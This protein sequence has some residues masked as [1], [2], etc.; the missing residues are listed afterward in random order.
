M[1]DPLPS[2]RSPQNV[3][4]APASAPPTVADDRP[5]IWTTFVV[6][7]TGLALAVVLQVVVAVL[8]AFGFAMLGVDR[9]DL[10]QRLLEWST[11]QS[12]FLV[13]LAVGQIGFAIPTLAAAAISPVPFKER[14]G[15][16]GL[17]HAVRFSALM[18]A[19]S[20]VPLA[21]ALGLATAVAQVVPENEALR[22]FYD[23]LTPARAIVFVLLVAL[24]PGFVEEL[25]F[26]GYIQRRLLARWRPGWAIGVT[27]LVFTLSHIEPVAM[28]A[29]LPLG[30]W[31]GIIAW[32]VGSIVPTIV[33]HAFVNGGLNL[34]RLTV[35]F[36]EL[37]ETTERVGNISFLAVGCVC[38]VVA[39]RALVKVERPQA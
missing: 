22:T 28:A 12:G 33:C 20:I 27:S 6:W 31:F 3:F 19:G 8:A 24:A 21:V 7:L 2:D 17:P 35:Q 32:R 16:V 4:A 29:A 15:L 5:R 10:R 23:Q 11:V 34:W 36:A 18:A 38:F 9:A 30:I 39:C 26:R 25:L 1:D 37:S 14:L 13:T